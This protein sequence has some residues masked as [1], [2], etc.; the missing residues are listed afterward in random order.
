[1]PKGHTSVRLFGVSYPNATMIWNSET[2][3]GSRGCSLLPTHVLDSS[4]DSLV[5]SRIEMLTPKSRIERKFAEI[6]IL[7]K[8]AQDDCL[9]TPKVHSLLR[10][11][12][13]MENTNFMGLVFVRTRAEVA[14]LSHILSL[15]APYFA[16][17]TFVGESGFSGRRKTVSELIDVR[18][19]KETL[20]DLRQGTINLV[21]T[22]NA[23]EEGIDV[24]ACNVV[25]CFDKPPNL[26]SFIQRRG[27]ARM[28]KSKYV[29]MFEDDGLANRA[30]SS[31]FELEER[32]R[33]AYM[34]DMRVL[35]EI[36]ELE[37]LKEEGRR[38]FSIVSTGYVTVK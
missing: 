10:C 16:I 13:E 9:L 15:H 29:I 34:D 18:K 11:L 26:K 4:H 27:R 22:T 19:Q 2:C 24:S 3:L 36:Q 5:L 23:L 14:V 33:I 32:M 21:V 35:Q 25:I 1:M 17:S 37:A 12:K 7:K 28:E 20:N 31:W 8:T 6:E 30:L 38:E